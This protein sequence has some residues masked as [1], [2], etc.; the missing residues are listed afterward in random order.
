MPANDF[1]AAEEKRA[2]TVS[3]QTRVREQYTVSKIF[4]KALPYF[5]LKR[6]FQKCSH[7]FATVDLLLPR[8]MT[9]NAG[10]ILISTAKNG[11]V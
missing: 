6:W 2:V 8:L 5:H 1:P 9:K 4:I 7:L 3:T 11:I 10:S